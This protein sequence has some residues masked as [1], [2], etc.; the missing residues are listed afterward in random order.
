MPSF[1]LST[2]SV[3]E[4]TLSPW[5]TL[6]SREFKKNNEPVVYHSIKQN[7][8]IAILAV[9][10]DQKIPLVRQ[11]RPAAQSFTL[12]L[13]AGL[14][15]KDEDPAITAQREL[16]EETG[17]SSDRKLQFMGSF[18]ADSGRLENRCW[19]YFADKVFRPAGRSWSEEEGIKIEL[20]S[21][22]QLKEAIRSGEFCHSMHIG[23]LG[24]AVLWKQFEF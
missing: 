18:Y 9:T 20:F 15:E 3:T 24:L 8:Y 16:W 7:D 6:V 17:F 19:F 11:Y 10:E 23:C 5:A 2:Q 4:T 1:D 21:K 12:E 22:A 13:P 14:V